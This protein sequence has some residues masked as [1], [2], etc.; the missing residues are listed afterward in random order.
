MPQLGWPFICQNSLSYLLDLANDPGAT[1]VAE[2]E[3]P[4]YEQ[5]PLLPGMAEVANVPW[6]Q[7]EI[8]ERSKLISE[9]AKN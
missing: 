8:E 5:E 9:L 7:V 3:K 2:G 1:L 4:T 6:K